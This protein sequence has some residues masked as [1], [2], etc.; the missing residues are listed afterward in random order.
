MSP[1]TLAPVTTELPRGIQDLIQSE[2]VPSQ[3]DSPEGVE[4]DRRDAALLYAE[5]K[6][7]P[8]EQGQ[9]RVDE[10]RDWQYGRGNVSALYSIET[11]PDG[12]DPNTGELRAIRVTLGRSLSADAALA[13]LT[14]GLPR[15]AGIDLI[16]TPGGLVTVYNANARVDS[17]SEEDVK[18]STRDGIN[19][20]ATAAAMLRES[21]REKQQ[22]KAS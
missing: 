10:S 13:P 21:N 14:R 20:A 22:T 18:L 2:M 11:G 16:I 19:A 17:G 15:D 7:N 6:A 4:Q 12:I 8:D 5:I 9:L 3:T 1:E